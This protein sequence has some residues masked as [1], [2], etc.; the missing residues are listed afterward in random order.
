MPPLE[1]AQESSAEVVPEPIDLAVILAAGEGSRLAGHGNG[2]PKPTLSLLGLS[3]G[4]RA[5]VAC[6]EAGIR[7]FVVVNYYVD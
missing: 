4:E 1:R 2:E 6:M 7:R 3:L 5:I